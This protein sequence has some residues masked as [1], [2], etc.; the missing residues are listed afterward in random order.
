MP[1]FKEDTRQL[2]AGCDPRV[3]S[4]LEKRTLVGQLEVFE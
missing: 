4:G 1:I 2:N 3:D